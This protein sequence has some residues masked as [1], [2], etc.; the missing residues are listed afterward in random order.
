MVK[1]NDSLFFMQHFKSVTQRTDFD[2]SER[3]VYEI[4]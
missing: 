1:K 3:K 4:G 2:S